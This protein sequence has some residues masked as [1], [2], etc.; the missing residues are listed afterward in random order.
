MIF[1]LNYCIV[2]H[3]QQSLTFGLDSEPL[4]DFPFEREP[5]G[6]FGVNVWQLHE[7]EVAGH[8][9]PVEPNIESHLINLYQEITATAPA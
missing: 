7:L 8:H 6:V 3:N 5:I 1:K 4:V 2:L 9:G